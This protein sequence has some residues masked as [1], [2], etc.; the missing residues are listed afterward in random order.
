MSELFSIAK[1]E[2]SGRLKMHRSDM[3]KNHQWLF[4]TRN[5]WFVVVAEYNFSDLRCFSCGS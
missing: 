3:T 1:V 4:A 2:L 5:R